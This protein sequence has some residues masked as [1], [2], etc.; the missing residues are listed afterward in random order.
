MLTLAGVAVVALLAWAVYVSYRVHEWSQFEQT[1]QQQPG[2]AVTSFEK[3]GGRYHIRGFRDPLAPDPAPLLQRAGLD[4]RKADF[5]LAP[6]YSA[7]DS[8]VERRAEQRL[9]PPSGVTLSVK[10]GVLYAEGFASPVW[11]ERLNDRGPWIAGVREIDST[12][13]QNAEIVELNRRKAVVQSLTLLFPLGRA[14][15]E[16]GQEEN[17]ANARREISG[18]LD[19]SA[20][21]NERSQI[22]IVGHT[23]TTGMEASNLPLSRQRAE[24]ILRALE[25]A[26]IKSSAFRAIGVGASQPLRGEDTDT[27]RRLN[28]SV[29]FRVTLSP[30]PPLSASSALN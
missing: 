5:E 2:I 11:I 28:R 25:R 7:E 12:K 17:L 30:T 3:Q 20:R 9:K 19:Q 27:G 18:L 8:I 4:A 10:N 6:F 29:T 24:Q 1:L 14:E 16:T 26:G 23:D 22:E 13:L 15:L 21:T